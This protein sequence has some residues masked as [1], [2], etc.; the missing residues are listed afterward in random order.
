MNKNSYYFFKWDIYNLIG[1]SDESVILLYNIE[2]RIK[3]NK[4]EIILQQN[5]QL[6]RRGLRRV[7][8]LFL[9]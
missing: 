2:K 4:K 6:L 3:M 9:S 8:G 1:M 5:I 7:Y